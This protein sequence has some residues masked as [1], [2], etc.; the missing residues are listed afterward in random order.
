M[1]AMAQVAAFAM[2]GIIAAMADEPRKIVFVDTG[3]TGRSMTAE[4]LAK[5]YIAQHQ[6][7]VAVIS[8]A[9]DMDPFGVT[10]EVNAATLLM[11]RGIDVSAHRATQLTANDV[12]HADLIVV[13]TE[14][15]KA[16]VI[17]QFPDAASK[18][19]LIAAYATG[20][21]GEVADAYGKPMPAYEEMVAQVG[22]YVP[23]VIDKAVKAPK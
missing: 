18:T 13:M 14:K 16:T 4:V 5:V 22:A 11:K 12:R 10:P 2:K 9:V 21:A 8:R 15:H 7:P 6:L 17:A 20:E 3:N 1:R 23:L 19:V